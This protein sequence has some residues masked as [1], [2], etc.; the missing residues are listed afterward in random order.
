M[1]INKNA[2]VV[3]AAMMNIDGG[4]GGGHCDEIY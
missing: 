1:T 4:D 3:V 2:V